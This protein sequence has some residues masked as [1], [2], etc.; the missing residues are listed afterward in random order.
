VVYGGGGIMPDVFVPADTTGFSDYYGKITSKGLVYR[1]AFDYAD[2]HRELLSKM[3]DSK[4]IEAYLKKQDVFSQFIRF[5]GK[6]GIP[7]DNKGLKISGK[8]LETQL[9]AY[10][11]RNI[12]GE[13]GFYPIVKEID[14]TLLKAIDVIESDKMPN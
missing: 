14:T 4:T 10:I 6:N 2:T 11:A 3:K 1:F 7:R 8:I 13:E 9:D 5:V 12:L